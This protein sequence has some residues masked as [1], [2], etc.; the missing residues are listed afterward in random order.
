MPPRAREHTI[1]YRSDVA[2]AA[3]WREYTTK[4]RERDL[5]CTDGDRFHAI[6]A[7][8]SNEDELLRVPGLLDDGIAEK[9][10]PYLASRA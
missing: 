5:G 10:K 3:I 9:G 4:L 6:V 8:V 1:S 2:A 7:V